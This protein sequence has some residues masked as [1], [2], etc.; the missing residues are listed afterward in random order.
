MI[1]IF[2]NARQGA[3]DLK[4][5]F[6]PIAKTIKLGLSSGGIVELSEEEENEIIEILMIEE[7]L[8]RKSHQPNLDP[9]RLLQYKKSDT[10]R[11]LPKLK[12]NSLEFVLGHIGSRLVIQDLSKEPH[13][14]IGGKTGSGKTVTLFN[15][16]VS[17][18]YSNTPKTLRISLIDP[19]ILTFGDSRIENSPFLNEAPSIGDT[20][21][22]LDILKSAYLE[23]MNRYKLM[24][25]NRVKDYR[26]IGLYAH[27]LFIDEIYELLTDK[28]KVEILSYLVKIASL[29][30][31]A[32]VHLV[33]A[34]QS[35][36]A[37]ILTGNLLANVSKIGH[38]V[39]NKTES[40]LLGFGE[41]HRLKGAGD[42]Y[43]V[44]N[45]D[46]DYSRFQATYI[47]IEDDNTYIYF[48][49]RIDPKQYPR[50]QPNTPKTAHKTMVS[51]V[52]GTQYTQD[53]ENKT[54]DT[55]NSHIVPLKINGE[56]TIKDKILMSGE[57]G[58]N[59]KIA[60]KRDIININ[61]RQEL[62]L[63]DSAIKKLLKENKIYFKKGIGYFLVA[64][65]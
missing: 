64:N 4:D 21:R 50:R 26:G 52:F 29:G 23:M 53:T 59:G 19:K 24:K 6:S 51:S 7:L 56:P 18:L 15:V 16:L 13:I 8:K 30:R 60:P 14:L 12:K 1:Q 43:K 27:V 44:L 5:I 48:N 38:L 47:D 31:Q 20:I 62:K 25:D 34:T 37:E 63:Y 40:Q 9:K 3:R 28:N 32:G 55:Q 39:T 36:R 58:E 65:N 45:G 33:L 11:H 54:K 17:L 57:S 61:N 49:G 42:G 35:I 10:L 41:A 2:K 46:S 22:A